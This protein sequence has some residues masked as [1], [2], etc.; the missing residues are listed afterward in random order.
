VTGEIIGNQVSSCGTGCTYLIKETNANANGATG[1][2]NM[3]DTMSM[4]NFVTRMNEYVTNN[5]SNSLNTPLKTWKLQN[6]YP[7]FAN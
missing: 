3:A 5:N 4:A 2:T 6:G 7:V 1:A